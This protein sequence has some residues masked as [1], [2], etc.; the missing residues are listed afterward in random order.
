MVSGRGRPLAVWNRLLLSGGVLSATT[1]RG[2]GSGEWQ[3]FMTT[4]SRSLV[5]KVRQMSSDDGRMLFS[6]EHHRLIASVVRRI[7]LEEQETACGYSFAGMMDTIPQSRHVDFRRHRLLLELKEDEGEKDENSMII[8]EIF[9]KQSYD[10]WRR[11]Q[12]IFV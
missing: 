10:Y 4:V 7:L 8:E 1:R 11:Q 12:E 6:T 2:V 3:R 9:Y 5:H